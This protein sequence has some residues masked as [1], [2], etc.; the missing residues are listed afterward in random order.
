M[1]EKYLELIKILR[2]KC[3]WDRKQTVKSSRRYILNEA[4]ELDEALL[5]R[6]YQKITEEIGDL[7]FTTLFVANILNEKKKIDFSEIESFTVKKIITRHPHVFSNHRVKNADEV[8]SRWE[9]IK[10]KES[11]IPMLERIP[12]TLPALRRAQL[13]QERVARVGFDWKK[14]EEVF[15]KIIEEIKELGSAM[16]TSNKKAIEEELGDLYFALVNLTR[17]LGLDAEEVLNKANK[18]FIDRFSK[19]EK[20]FKDQ[21]KNLHQVTLKEMDQIWEKLKQGPRKAKKIDF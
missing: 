5:T 13:I 9:V 2:K 19:L 18:K 10:T 20:H 7:I 15:K 14:K 12:K 21:N 4:Y 8:L 16:Q 6:D 17:H 1:F 3:P 11:N